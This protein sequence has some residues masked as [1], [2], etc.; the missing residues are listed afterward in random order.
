MELEAYVA[1]VAHGEVFTAET[2]TLATLVP[3]A[4][5]ELS[6]IDGR[7]PERRVSTQALFVRS[8]GGDGAVRRTGSAPQDAVQAPA[9]IC[10][11]FNSVPAVAPNQLNWKT[12]L[13]Y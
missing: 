13:A 3:E 9:Y 4:G 8:P 11:I 1:D 5:P 7:F 12:L 10:L 2:L 6:A